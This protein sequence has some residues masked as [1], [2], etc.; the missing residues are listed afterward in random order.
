LGTERG[1]GHGELVV[2]VEE[3][4]GLKDAEIADHGQPEIGLTFDQGDR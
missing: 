2:S 1:C 4:G 3:I